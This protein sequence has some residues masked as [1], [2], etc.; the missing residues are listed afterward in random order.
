MTAIPKL[1]P[2]EVGQRA[3]LTMVTTWGCIPQ[4]TA[5]DGDSWATAVASLP[6]VDKGL[7]GEQGAEGPSTLPCSEVHGVSSENGK[8][9]PPRTKLTIEHWSNIV[10]TSAAFGGL[11][12]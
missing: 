3:C 9:R 5:V 4:T 11:R 6:G 10:K 7:K 2:G 8:S 12:A 1:K